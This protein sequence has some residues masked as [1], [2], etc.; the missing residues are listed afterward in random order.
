M[1][2]IHAPR[3]MG[4][5]RCPLCASTGCSTRVSMETRASRQHVLHDNTCFTTTRASRHRHMGSATRALQHVLHDIATW[6][7]Q[8]GLCNTGSATR[9]LQHGLCITTSPHGTPNRIN[10]ILRHHFNASMAQCTM[11]HPTPCLPP[12][13]HCRSHRSLICSHHPQPTIK[14]NEKGSSKGSSNTFNA[15][16]MQFVLRGEWARSAVVQ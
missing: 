15:V 3:S 8:H 6:A 16:C 7:L 13:H 9:A 14:L 10:L 12:R 5:R 4:M 2:H 11:V 1:L